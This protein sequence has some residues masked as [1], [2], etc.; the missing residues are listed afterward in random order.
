MGGEGAG[1][2]LQALGGMTGALGGV[3]PG[4]LCLGLALHFCN[5]LL[6]GRGW[7]AIV[8]AA[9]DGPTRVTRRDAVAAWIAGAGAAGVL[10][11]QVGDALRIW[12]LSRR[13]PDAGYALVAGT[14][15][16]EGAGEL[17]AGLPL[18]VVAVA[19]GVGPTLA[20]TWTAAAGVAAIVIVV[21]AAAVATRRRVRGR[22]VLVQLRHGC[23]PL[24][25]PRTYARS[26]TPWQLASRTCRIAAVACFLGAFHLPVTPQTVLVVV[27]AQASGRVLSFAPAAL[28]AGVAVLAAT[29]GAAAHD[30]VGTGRLAAFLVGTTTLLT[31]MGAVVATVVV[32]RNADWRT[33]VRATR[34][35]APAEAPVG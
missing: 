24:A 17:V 26:V 11:A 35:T 34:R 13:A 31:L 16:A 7:W 15:V 29:F 3:A 20:A 8:R 14:L 32:V 22:P 33:L 21:G 9:H 27:F 6:R 12:L 5:Q 23:A 28:G 19:V 10:T 18:P 2:L 1:D 4:W 25:A 30:D